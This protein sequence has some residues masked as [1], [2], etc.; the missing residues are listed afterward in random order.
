MTQLG[1]RAAAITTC[2]LALSGCSASIKGGWEASGHLGVADPFA[3]DLTFTTDA[4]GHATFADATAQ[5]RPVPVCEASLRDNRVRFVIDAGGKTTCATLN[6]P[7]A[8]SGVLG[9]DVISGEI[10][11]AAGAKVGIWRAFRRPKK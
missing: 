6:K 5:S 4:L 8:F 3:L 2:A 9:E 10:S 7:L 1:R 11:D